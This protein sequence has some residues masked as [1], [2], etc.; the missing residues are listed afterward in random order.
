MAIKAK[1]EN[2]VSS[3][4]LERKLDLEYL[5]EHMQGVRNPERFPGLVYKLTKPKVAMLLFRTGKVIC[6]GA[7]SKKDITCAVDTLLKELRR[8]RI[9]VK[10]KPLIKIQNIVASANLGFMVNLDTLVTKC[11]S[12]EYE[13]EQFPGLVYRLDEPKTVMLIF[14]SGS[15]I[16]T[17]AKSQK[18]ANIAGEKTR[19]MVEECGA[20]ITGLKKNPNPA[21]LDI[22]PSLP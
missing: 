22:E 16:I 7:L 20:V 10:N 3:I 5:A 18:G 2:I 6:S 17:G 1:I 8:C 4:T 12:T 19:M 11:V 9:R 13:P 15:I 14:R 21:N